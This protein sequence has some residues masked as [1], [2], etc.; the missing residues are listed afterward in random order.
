MDKAIYNEPWFAYVAECH[1]KTLYVGVARDVKKRIADHNKTNKCK[2][3][4]YRKP[5]K[6]KYKELCENYSIARK[7]ESEIKKFS[8]KKKL[9]LIQRK[10]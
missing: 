3:T 1:D 2:Y 8:R 4:R 9:D 5:I 6:L 10:V 7:R